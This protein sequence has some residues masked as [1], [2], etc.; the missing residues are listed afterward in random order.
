MT[1]FVTWQLIVTLDSIPNSC[2][3]H[4]QELI[5]IITFWWRDR[6]TEKMNPN[7]GSWRNFNNFTGMCRQFWDNWQIGN[8]CRKIAA[9]VAELE[10]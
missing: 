9:I 1:I 8:P 5:K 4:S 2:D 7:G 3:V 6:F 10:I